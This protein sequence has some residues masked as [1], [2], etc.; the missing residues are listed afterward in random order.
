MKTLKLAIS[1][2]CAAGSYLPFGKQISKE[3][4]QGFLK[5]E[6]FSQNV[7]VPH[8]AAHLDKDLD[9]GCGRPIDNLKHKV[10]SNRLIQTL[11]PSVQSKR[12]IHAVDD[13]YTI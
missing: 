6:V 1:V 13:W 10:Q 8:L 9:N 12:L 11:K 4:I 2:Q 7:K 3:A 5:V